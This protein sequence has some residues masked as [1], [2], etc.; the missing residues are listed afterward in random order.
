MRITNQDKKYKRQ[1]M[2]VFLAYYN[3]EIDKEEFE[4]HVKALKPGT[5]NPEKTEV[6]APQDPLFSSPDAG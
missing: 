6:S 5:F 2:A 4:R 3:G 1:C